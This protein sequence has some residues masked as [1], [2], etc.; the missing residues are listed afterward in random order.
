M[1]QNQAARKTGKKR[2]GKGPGVPASRADAPPGPGPARDAGVMSL[3]SRYVRRARPADVKPAAPASHETDPVA[4]LYSA[5]EYDYVLAIVENSIKHGTAV[6]SQQAWRYARACREVGEPERLLANAAA[7]GT[8]AWLFRGF[9]SQVFQALV[10]TDRIAEARAQVRQSILAGAFDVDFLLRVASD[11]RLLADEALVLAVIDLVSKTGRRGA[12]G[13]EA[14]FLQNVLLSLGRPLDAVRIAKPR[15]DEALDADRYFLL[16]NAAI[17]SGAPREAIDHFNQ[18]LS[19]YKLAPVALR[20]ADAPLSVLNLTAG[21]DL[22]PRHG[23]PVTVAMSCFNARAT[24]LSALAALSAQT[25]RDIEILVVDDCSKDDTAALVARY[26]AETDDRVRLIRMEKNGGAYRS[27][28]R[29][30][31]E[32]KGT[33]FTCTDAD[34]WSHPEKIA[35]LV[36][37]LEK[38]GTAAVSSR[39][40]RLNAELGIKPRR[41]G[42][43][44]ADMSSTLF[45]RAPVVERI[46]YYDPVRFG[47]DSEYW[48]RLEVAFGENAVASLN[49][50]LLVADW[51]ETTLT[52]NR[53]TGITDGGVFYPLRGRY[54]HAYRT[55]HARGEAIALDADGMPRELPPPVDAAMAALPVY[56]R[57]TTRKG[58]HLD[59]TRLIYRDPAIE[60]FWDMPEGFGMPSNA[61]LGLAEALL[62]EPLGRRVA[63]EEKDLPGPRAGGRIGVAYSGGIDSTAAL[64]LLPDPIPI[65]TEV[66]RPGGLHKLDNERLAVAE[67]GGMT[68]VS[69]CDE[70]PMLFGAPRGHY[71]LPGFTV[72]AVLLAD[73][74]GLRTIADGNVVDTVYLLGPGGHGT[75]YNPQDPTKLLAMFARAGLQYCSPVG[76]VSEVTTDRLARDVPHAM[77]CMRGEHGEPCNACIKCYRKRALRGTPIPTSPAVEKALARDPIRMLGGLLWARDHVG[78]SHPRIDGLVKDISWVDKW[79]PRSIE[80]IPEDL[81]PYFLERLAHY[82]IA[83]LEDATGLE[84]WDARRDPPAPASTEG[85]TDTAERG[86]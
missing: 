44:H 65:H 33:Y 56:Q 22:A 47:A 60:L 7:L 75:L 23:P 53:S 32:A 45:R 52:S 41:A 15:K 82:G 71:G 81:R 1:T 2:G 57:R 42:Y 40:V 76:G 17:L 61:L 63:V 79:Y 73:H 59:G 70:L 36:D 21:R 54:R 37:T 64:K 24:V 27:R 26:A 51:S 35:L 67:V 55:R 9:R 20:D 43:S 28:N 10:A 34:D 29:A 38:R 3:L 11:Y 49:R 86:G 13:A 31:A 8:D 46:G 5:G 4:A 85:G 68:V 74:L 80:M 66:A 84:A 83:P 69:N 6:G 62:F 78:L 39:L 12:S 77:G 18:A 58:W 25:Y 50:V 16:A 30:L 19:R 72:T 14:I 48:S